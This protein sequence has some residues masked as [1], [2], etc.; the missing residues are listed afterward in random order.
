MEIEK[1][2]DSLKKEKK[3]GQ[4][5][6]KERGGAKVVKEKG[7]DPLTKTGRE[8]RMENKAKKRRKE[9]FRGG[10]ESFLRGRL[11]ELGVMGSQMQCCFI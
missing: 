10:E 6:G 8:C 5:L 9:K 7:E 2:R 3:L 11:G 4:T 1:I